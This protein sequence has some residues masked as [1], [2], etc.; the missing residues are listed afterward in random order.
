M[1]HIRGTIPPPAVRN[2]NFFSAVSVPPD[3]QPTSS[4]LSALQQLLQESLEYL[5]ENVGL[6]LKR[7]SPYIL[8]RQTGRTSKSRR[9]YILKRSVMY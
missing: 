4:S 3:T 9:P 5:E 1:C 6:P 7:K 2:T 8:K